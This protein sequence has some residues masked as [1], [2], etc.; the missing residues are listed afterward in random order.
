LHGETSGVSASLSPTTSPATN[1]REWESHG[2]RGTIQITRATYELVRHDFHCEPRG[3]IAVK[4]KGEMEVW[5]VVG[6]R[7]ELPSTTGVRRV[8]NRQGR[9]PI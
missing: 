1:H 5:H 7:S 6:S 8:D 2:E 9:T 4:G 3:T